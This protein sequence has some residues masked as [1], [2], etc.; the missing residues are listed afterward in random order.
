[1]LG[2]QQYKSPPS[3]PKL[4]VE[5]NEKEKKVV[6]HMSA[7]PKHIDLIALEAALKVSEV[8]S[9]LFQLEMKGIVMAQ[10]GKQFKTI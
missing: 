3:Q 6:R 2:W 4:F 7:T 10:A 5:L 1:M 9:I 8:A